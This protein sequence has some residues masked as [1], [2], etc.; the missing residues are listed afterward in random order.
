MLR[1]CCCCCSP[2]TQKR[3][4]EL[5]PNARRILQ[6]LPAR[7]NPVVGLAFPFVTRD[8]VAEVFQKNDDLPRYFSNLTETNVDDL[9]R[10]LQNLNSLDAEKLNIV[11]RAIALNLESCDA[12]VS[13][14]NM[15]IQNLECNTFDNVAKI[16]FRPR[17]AHEAAAALTFLEPHP[18][19]RKYLP[20]LA[21]PT[22]PIVILR[23]YSH[24]FHQP[25]INKIWAEFCSFNPKPKQSKEE[26]LCDVIVQVLIGMK[27]DNSEDIEKVTEDMIKELNF[28]PFHLAE[29][30]AKN[31]A[32]CFFQEGIVQQK[33]LQNYEVSFSNDP[34]ESGFSKIKNIHF[35][36]EEPILLIDF[37]ALEDEE[38]KIETVFLMHSKGE[39]LFINPMSKQNVIGILKSKSKADPVTKIE[40]CNH[41]F[42]AESGHCHILSR[43]EFEEIKQAL[44]S[45]QPS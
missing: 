4:P 31:V 25:Y 42:Y 13:G 21:F 20:Q 39:K 40:I 44:N 7:K 30:Q 18:F 10:S 27:L 9:I 36:F 19:L 3:T 29:V 11:I 14:V 8:D 34:V 12:I 22:A 35:A 41:F 45:A 43:Y 16:L 2:K 33:G 17:F 1:V 23:L 38:E 5:D 37:L 24:L 32:S 28:L 15:L 26:W 6:N